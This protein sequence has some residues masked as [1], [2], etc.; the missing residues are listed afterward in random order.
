MVSIDP[1][2]HVITALQ[3]DSDITRSLHIHAMNL[4]SCGKTA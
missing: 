3:R 2:I 1:P 4:R